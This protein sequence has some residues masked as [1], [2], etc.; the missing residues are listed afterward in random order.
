MSRNTTLP[1]PQCHVILRFK[2]CLQVMNWKAEERT[3]K[4]SPRN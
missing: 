1:Q 3:E 4:A 2:Q